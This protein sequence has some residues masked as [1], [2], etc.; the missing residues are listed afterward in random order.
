MLQ[1]DKCL[2]VA[3]EAGDIDQQLLEQQMDFRRMLLEIARIDFQILDV[4]LRHAPLDAAAY[5]AFL[6]QREIVSGAGTQQH[7]Y[8]VHATGLAWGGLRFFL[9]DAQVPRI[10][11]QPV[12]HFLH[13]QDIGGV[14]RLYRADRHAVVFRGSRVLHQRNA[15]RTL[16]GAQPQRAVG[17]GAGQDNADSVFP[18][19]FGQRAQ[20]GVDYHALSARH[21][22][23][24]QVQFAME[25]GHV[26]VGRDR[27]HAIW[28]HLDLIQRLDHMHAGRA[29]QNLG[30]HAGVIGVEV[31]HQH[32]SHAAVG[33]DITEKQFERFQSTGGSTDAYYGETAAAG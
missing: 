28:Q 21:I 23:R 29:L 20:E 25:D 22:R 10:A 33:R 12:R 8:P 3:E 1:R 9:L 26:A 27:I 15:A 6:V 5:G 2:R 4:V 31:R 17:T 24:A 32:E 18:L 30:E 7:Q 19:I 11:Q 16:N 13:R 14:A